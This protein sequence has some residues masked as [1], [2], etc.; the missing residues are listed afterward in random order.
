[1]SDYVVGDGQ[2]LAAKLTSGPYPQ[3][4]VAAGDE[5]QR[6]WKH[7]KSTGGSHVHIDM[8]PW[9]GFAGQNAPVHVTMKHQATTSKGGALMLQVASLIHVW[10]HR[11]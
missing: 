2:T 10:R 1:M 3:H 8:I 6:H 11:T 9:T 7:S 4:E 5:A